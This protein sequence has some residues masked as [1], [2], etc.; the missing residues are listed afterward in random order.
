MADAEAK[1]AS[2]GEL[3]EDTTGFGGVEW[4]TA[5]DLLL[6]PRAVLDA[7]EAGGATGGGRYAR[8]FRFYL[9][10]CGVLMF[11]LFLV[12]G[13]KRMIEQTPPQLLDRAIAVAG[14]SREAFVNDADGW[15]TF[16]I[17]PILALFYAL[18]LAPAI[19][20]WGET[21]WRVAFRAT[22][23]LMCA[24]T[25]P[26]L[27]LGPLPYLDQFG[28]VSALAMYALLVVAFVRMGRGRWWHSRPQ[29]VGR[30]I[31]LL[32]LIQI[33]VLVGTIPVMAVGLLGGIY[34]S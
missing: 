24:W 33:G 30:S 1:R 21:G 15:L 29:A 28:L 6:R 5:R 12:G 22:F 10:L 20:R 26:V 16:T 23:A 25:V 27:A 18:A 11:F 9:A 2:L 7:Y 32:I 34:G 14:K 19:K 13:T 8:P 4:H 3:A 17:T 31:I